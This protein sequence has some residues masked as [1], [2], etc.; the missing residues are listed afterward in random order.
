MFN[1]PLAL[2]HD[3]ADSD[4]SLGELREAYA[5]YLRGREKPASDKT[6]HHYVDTL[7]SFEK[8]LALHGKPAVLGQLTPANVR[9]WVSDQRAGRLPSNSTRPQTKCSDQTIRPRHAA[10]KSF[11]HK[12]ILKELKLTRRD[13]LEEVERFEQELPA[14]E[15]LDSDELAR[16]RAS[17][18]LPTFEHVRDRAI[19]E[20]HMATAFR[21]DAVRSLPLAALDRVSGRVEVITKGGKEMKG[22]LDPNAMAHVRAYLRLRPETN[23]LQ[24]FVTEEGHGLTY[25]GGRMIWRRIQRRSGVKRLGSHLVRHTFAQA[26]ARK[27]APIADIQD[28]LGHTSD[29]MA[30]HYAGEARKAA[31][32][33]LMAKHSLAS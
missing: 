31:A 5:D 22:R 2:F 10:I 3:R 30:R 29:K 13:L 7:L 23:S 25:W 14:K 32:A 26:M 8:S 27:G 18:R 9:T 4:V 6:I 17:F 16:V 24:L 19:F 12:Y 33:E 21:F 11:T 1:T 15:E 28:V 20:I